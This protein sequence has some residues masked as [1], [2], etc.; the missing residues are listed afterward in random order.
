MF[1]VETKD[2]LVRLIFLLSIEKG[3]TWDDPYTF[4]QLDMI[5]KDV[6]LA[7]VLTKIYGMGLCHAKI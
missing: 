1:D 2:V 5:S 7:D 6:T 4:D 3:F